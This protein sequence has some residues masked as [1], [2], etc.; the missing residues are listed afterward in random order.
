[1]CAAPPHEPVQPLLVGPR[2][3]IGGA[4]RIAG[5]RVLDDLGVRVVCHALILAS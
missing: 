1:M 2:E 5:A 4:A 3:Q